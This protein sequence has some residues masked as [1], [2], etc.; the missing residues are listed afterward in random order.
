M[1][2]NKLT[3]IESMITTAVAAAAAVIPTERNSHESQTTVCSFCRV[4]VAQTLLK[5]ANSAGL[6]KSSSQQLGSS[7]VVL[8]HQDART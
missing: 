8:K 3:I 2:R 5:S 6:Q 7:Q 4:Y 1:G